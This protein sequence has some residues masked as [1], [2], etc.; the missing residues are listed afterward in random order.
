[1]KINEKRLLPLIDAIIIILII[2]DTFLL[3]LISFY[4]INPGIVFYVIYFDL[5][6]CCIL[7]LEFIYRVR[8]VEEKRKYIL[9]H[10]YDIVA[11]IPLD[12]IAYNL[13][14]LRAFRFIRFIRFLRYVRLI[15]I[16]A[17]VRKSIRH[18]GEFI[19]ET[20]M[21][22]S[23]GIL[24]FTIFAGTIIFYLLESG[25]NSKVKTLWDSFWYVMPTVATTGSVDIVPQTPAGQVI[26][27]FLMLIGLIFFGMLTASIAYWYIER[28]EKKNRKTNEQDLDEVKTLVKS[29][30]SEIQE[31]KELLKNKK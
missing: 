30:Q 9:T 19:Q 7:F 26:S 6:V 16:F 22:L 4:D 31:L 11:M 18:F 20:H 27:M 23:L 10:W 25:V 17:L 28:L 3:L 5:A 14:A 21:H 8:K 13:I 24:I 12:F 15:R 2:V 29:M 1:M